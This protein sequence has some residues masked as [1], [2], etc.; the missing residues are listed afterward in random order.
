MAKLTKGPPSV[1]NKG[2][3]NYL[4]IV[5]REVLQEMRLGVAA[6]TEAAAREAVKKMPKVV[7]KA[8]WHN[9]KVES[10]KIAS[11]TSKGD[12]VDRTGR[13]AVPDA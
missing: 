10:S 2:K 5:T 12:Y 1:D 7:G 4:V 13:P 3:K 6:E 9:V 11:V 8:G